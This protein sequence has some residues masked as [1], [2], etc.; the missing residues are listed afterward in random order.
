MNNSENLLQPEEIKFLLNLA[1]QV[2][3]DTA[4]G[5]ESNHP[6]YFSDNLKTKLGVFVT[7]H[8]NADLRGCI[9][10]HTS[11]RPLYQTV[12]EMAVSAAC[13]DP[14]FPPLRKSELDRIKIKVSV[15]LMSP[16]KVQSVDQI[17]LG[18]HGII[19]KKGLRQST[20]LPEVAV[21]QG[22]DKQTTFRYLS[23]KA[24]L[25]PDAWKQGA[26]FLIYK[27]QVFG[28]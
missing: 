9:G 5:V 1:R 8:K 19:F 12:S 10:T 26:E 28:E 11:D 27:T 4:N 20:F 24:G 21:E 22:W 13:R 15:Y 17:K 16:T 3:T 6:N 14:R 18:E 2:I 23:T 25:S 7:L